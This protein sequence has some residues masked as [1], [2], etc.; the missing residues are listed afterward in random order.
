MD[1]TEM[2][3]V[4]SILEKYI[5]TREGPEMLYVAHSLAWVRSHG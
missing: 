5:Q 2:G 4:M 3:D 1:G